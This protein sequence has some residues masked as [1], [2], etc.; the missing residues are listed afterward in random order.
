MAKVSNEQL[1]EKLTSLEDQLADFQQR[2]GGILPPL[3][4]MEING[5]ARDMAKGNVDQ[6]VEWNKRK[7]AE[8]KKN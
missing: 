6:L 5:V 3:Q 8:R 2:L 1:Y 7:K 4:E